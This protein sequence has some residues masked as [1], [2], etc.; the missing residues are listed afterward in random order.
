MTELVK[1]EPTTI[2]IKPT[3]GLAALNL[4]DLWTYRE[5]VYFMIWRDIRVRYKQT[6]LGAAWAIIQPVL[7][8]LVFTFI[9]GRVAKLPTDGNIPYPIFS[10]VALLPWGLFVTALNQA[11]RSLTSNNNM[12]TKIYFPRLVLPLASVLSGLVDFVIAFVILIG[13]MLYYG[14]KPT[15]TALWA[16]PLLLLLALITALGVAL[17]LSALNVQYRDV[18]YALPFL[19]QF[20]QF[21]SPVAYSAKIISQKWQLVYSLNPMAGVVNGFR[22]A[23][24]G[25]DTGPGPEMA[26]SVAISL[27]IL[28][29]GLFYFRNMEKTFADTI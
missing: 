7:S 17:W 27:L 2:Y 29:G 13:M 28:I 16:L 12:I 8:M 18:N 24:L 21:L 14:I 22:W 23:L 5:L 9:F 19:T 6:M 1:H 20:W 10:Y 11:S 3:T 15:I 26:I 4:R 25:T